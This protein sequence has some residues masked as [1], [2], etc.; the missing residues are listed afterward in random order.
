VAAVDTA[1][2]DTAVAAADVANHPAVAV[3]TKLLSL[4]TM[5]TEKPLATI[6]GGFFIW[7]LKVEG[8]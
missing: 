7:S 4:N 6:V 1:V 2:A 5:K 8:E 3:A